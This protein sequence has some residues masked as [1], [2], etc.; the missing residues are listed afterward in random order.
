MTGEFGLNAGTKH[1]ATNFILNKGIA[2]YMVG[3][4]MSVENAFNNPVL[5]SGNL[6]NLFSSFLVIATVN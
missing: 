5:F 4:G 2:S 3:I 1:R 6:Q